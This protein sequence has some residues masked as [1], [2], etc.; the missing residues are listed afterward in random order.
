MNSNEDKVKISDHQE[1]IA[2]I[3][4]DQNQQLSQISEG[5][6]EAIPI[7]SIKEAIPITG[8]KEAIPITG[9]KE[10]IPI[11]GIKEEIKQPSLI[12]Q[13]FSYISSLIKSIEEDE[14]DE[15][16]DFYAIWLSLA[17]LGGT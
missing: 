2:E 13:M 11:T 9:I 5:L 14:D 10:A 7:T 12:H 17:F 1:K 3:L 8:I 16:D 4:K 15:D 6:K